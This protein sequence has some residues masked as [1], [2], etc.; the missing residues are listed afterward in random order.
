MSRGGSRR[1]ERDDVASEG[2]HAGEAARIDLGEI[3]GKPFINTASFGGYT[4]M[5][6]LR[7]QLQK[8]IGRWPAHF[9]AVAL[10]LF[11][12]DPLDLEIDGEHRSA[13]MVFIGNGRHEPSG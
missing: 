5:L 3:A 6:E 9:A 10:A 1:A 4:L 11:K 8:R 13:W 2:L 7:A 12:A